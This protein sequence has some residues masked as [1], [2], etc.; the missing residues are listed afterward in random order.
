MIK[1]AIVDDDINV[2][3]KIEEYILSY[4]AAI[5]ESFDV[6][7]FQ[8]GEK[9]LEY[10]DEQCQFDLIFLDIE[11]YNLNGIEVGSI[12]RKIKEN[13][14]VQIIYI[15]AKNTY[16]MKLFQNRPFDFIVKPVNKE[17]IWSV[18]SDYVKEFICTKIYY[19]YTINRKEYSILVDDII[20]IQSNRKKLLINTRKET[21]EIYGKLDDEIKKLPENLFL[22]I[23]RCYAVNVNYISRFSPEEITLING[24]EFSISKTFQDKVSEKL[25]SSVH[26]KII[27]GGE[28]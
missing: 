5:S 20:Y 26:D 9:F 10:W 19:K 7:T 23:H 25:L 17:K 14:K 22:R 12:L 13:Y 1:V 28:K 18:L 11:L 2:C 15:S 4:A 21:I 27:A 3:F 6:E 8:S 24:E 16:A